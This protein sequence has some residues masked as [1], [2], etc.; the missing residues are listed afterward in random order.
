MR[1]YANPNVAQVRTTGAVGSTNCVAVEGSDSLLQRRNAADVALRTAGRGAVEDCPEVNADGRPIAQ[2]KDTWRKPHGD[3][4]VFGCP[5]NYEIPDAFRSPGDDC[6]AVPFHVAALCKRPGDT[7][8]KDFDSHRDSPSQRKKPD[9]GTSPSATPSTTA[10]SFSHVVVSRSTQMLVLTWARWGR[11][12]LRI[13]QEERVKA[14]QHARHAPVPRVRTPIVSPQPTPRRNFGADSQ[15]KGEA[16]NRLVERHGRSLTV[17]TPSM[18]EDMRQDQR[19]AMDEQGARTRLQLTLLGGSSPRTPVPTETPDFGTTTPNFVGSKSRT[20]EASLASSGVASPLAGGQVSPWILE[21]E[22]LI[23]GNADDPDTAART[24][25]HSKVVDA[26]CVSLTALEDDESVNRNSTNLPVVFENTSLTGPEK[27]IMDD[28]ELDQVNFLA[29]RCGPRGARSENDAPRDLVNDHDVRNESHQCN[30]NGS[31]AVFSAGDRV[32]YFSKSHEQWMIAWVLERKS[33]NVYIIDK[34]GKGCLSKAYAADLI[35]ELE[36]Q[37]DPILR[38]VAALELCPSDDDGEDDDLIQIIDSSVPGSDPRGSGNLGGSAKNSLAPTWPTE[39]IPL[40]AG[41]VV[42]DDFSSDSD[43]NEPRP[44]S[45]SQFAI[46]P[47]HLSPIQSKQKATTST[48]DEYSGAQPHQPTLKTRIGQVV[49]DDFSSDSE[50]EQP[51]AC[52]NQGGVVPISPKAL[53]Q[54]HCHNA[55]PKGVNAIKVGQ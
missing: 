2:K 42:R 13:K 28:D 37:R 16:S 6:K 22:A 50:D 43:E 36:M 4:P 30:Q 47:G 20:M 49:R 35:S 9:F 33:T 1:K 40:A 52:K 25:L 34:Q 45:N 38:A 11:N 24:G 10:S 54:H 17:E 46:S 48:C 7:N 5:S 26:W 41:K 3:L 29:S 8:G 27:T 39:K 31:A 19:Y 21:A 12:S 18:F 32:L 44:R 55:G 15:A 14:M 53:L 51:M 23:E